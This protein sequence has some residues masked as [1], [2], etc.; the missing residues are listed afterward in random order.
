MVLHLCCEFQTGE[1]TL[2]EK[3]FWKR[4]WTIFKQSPLS[5]V[6]NVHHS[7]ISPYNVKKGVSRVGHTF[8]KSL[9]EGRGTE[10]NNSQS[11]EKP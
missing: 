10:L 3:E 11:V 7:C 4:D 5:S 8:W 6:L 1:V 9:P 2:I